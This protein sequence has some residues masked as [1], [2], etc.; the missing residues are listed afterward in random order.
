MNTISLITDFGLSD[1]FAGVMKGV[2]LNINPDAKIVDIC[3]EVKPQDI[4][5]AAFLLKGSFRYF[6]S[7]TVHLVVVD[8]GVGSERS[9]ILVKTKKY[10]FVGPDNGVLSLALKEEPPIKIIEITNRK[11]FLRPVSDTFH[12]RDI[13]AP[14]AAYLSCGLDID[15]FG[16]PIKSIQPLELPKIKKT[17]KSL[18]GEIIYIDRFGNLVSNIDQD[19]FKNFTKNKKFKIY[20]KDK[21]IDKLSHSYTEEHPLKPL[22]IMDS[23]HYLEIALNSGSAKDYLGINRAEKVV[24]QR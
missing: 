2:I 23:F 20:I 15:E 24:I 5:E 1:N 8:P 17:E 10:F 16:N 3:H 9:K 18:S 14:V 6:P 19:T 7:G 21:I 22:A 12:G 13:F 11:Y 4:F